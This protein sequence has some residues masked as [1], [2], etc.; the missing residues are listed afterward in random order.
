MVHN[1]EIYNFRELRSELE[2]L[3]HRFRS[4]SDTEV[5]LRAWEEWGTD[6]I[7]RF[8]GMF[9][10]AIHDAAT[11]T[12]FVARDRLGVKP[13]HYVELADGALAFASELKGLLAHPLL[14]RAPDIRAVEDY[15][16]FGYVPD[17]ACIVAG[18]RKL[19]AGHFLL[20]ER[21]RQLGAPLF[22]SGSA[23]HAVPASVG[24]AHLTQG[25]GGDKRHA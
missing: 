19:P 17:D 21:G 1:G 13:L 15:L 10:F 9:A 24:R 25:G 4:S 6:C 22:Q 2:S 16:A 23:R 8:N 14:R 3:G 7:L 20:V 5:V 11:Q 18:V 12:L